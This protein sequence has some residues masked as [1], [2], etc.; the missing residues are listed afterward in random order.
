MLQ[1][2]F[3]DK[4]VKKSIFDREKLASTE[5]SNFIAIPHP[6]TNQMKNPAIAVAVL[7]NPIIW[8]KEKVQIIFLLSI[9]QNLYS[10]WESIFKKIYNNFIEGSSG[11]IL[12]KTRS[13]TTLNNELKY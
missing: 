13:F 10:V 2:G 11:E 4:N 9:P 5:F 12:L 8:N 6:L 7:K 1:L 3:I